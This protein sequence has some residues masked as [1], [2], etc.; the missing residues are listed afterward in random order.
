[1]SWTH[2]S[3]V[4][5]VAG[6]G[7]LTELAGDL[8]GKNVLLLTSQ[9]MVRRGE[10][11]KIIDSCPVASW[12][13]ETVAPNPD[14]DELD[15]CVLKLHG[16]RFDLLLA[17]GGGSV[18]DAGKALAASLPSELD[19]PLDAWLRKGS[20]LPPITRVL[21]LFCIP[22]TA[23]TGA[24]VTPFGTIWD[25]ARSLKRSIA[26]P[27]LYPQKAIL[28]PALTLTLPWLETLAG[29]MDAISH[30]METLWNRRATPLSLAFARESL[31]LS[32]SFFPQVEK[33]PENIL[34]RAALQNSALLGGMA[35][36]QSRTAIAHSLSYSLTLHYGVPHGLACSFSLPG[37]VNFVQEKNLWHDANDMELAKQ[38][39]SLVRKHK[40][41][42]HILR[43]CSQDDVIARL[44]EMLVSDR[45]DNFVAKISSE[46]LEKIIKDSFAQE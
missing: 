28:D 16:S 38:A 22:T 3:P 18:M 2:H 10:A 6:H 35:I 1:M 12:A 20:G 11:Q 45:S 4:S 9:G 15:K 39:S 34:F 26:H 25:N 42:G 37:I 14:I 13:I 7:A 40:L 41:A 27:L 24:E 30:S 21:P 33:E 43:Y 44:G 31:R 32:L 8:A 36:S 29:A 19:A 46:E 5:I 23:G 17:M